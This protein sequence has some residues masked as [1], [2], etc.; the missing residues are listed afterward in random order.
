MIYTNKT[1]IVNET[2]VVVCKEYKKLDENVC[3]G[4]AHEYE[5][6]IVLFNNKDLV[7][8]YY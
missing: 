8:F 7:F 6:K 5:V 1:A 4:A 3:L 2:L